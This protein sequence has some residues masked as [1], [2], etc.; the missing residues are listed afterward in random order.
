MSGDNVQPKDVLSGRAILC[1]LKTNIHDHKV[2]RIRLDELR[3]LVEALGLE[4]VSEIVQTR[5]RQFSKYCVGKGKVKEIRSLAEKYD[6]KLV[7]FYNLI[8]SSQKL[9]LIHDT[10]CDVLDR[11]E[12][13]LEIFDQ[14]ASDNLSKL[15]I[16][17]AKL[18]KLSPF[19]KLAA[20]I[21]F[22]HDRPFFHSSGEYAFRAQLREITRRRASI[23]RQIADMMVEKRHQI[24]GRRRLGYPSICIAGYY[25]AGKTS[26][27]NA[28]TGDSKPVSERPFTTLISKYQKRFIDYETTVLFVDTIGFVLDLD[29]RLIKSFQ[30]NFEDIRSADLVILLFEI[31]DPPI[32]LTMKLAEGI[33]LLKDIGVP[34]EKIILVFNKVDKSPEAAETISKDLNLERYGMPW[35]I[36]SA[37]ERIN[38]DGLLSLI[39]TRL[40]ELKGK[41]VETPE[42]E[43][44][45]EAG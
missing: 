34:T 2:F 25:N 6:V 29:H 38:L 21:H 31:T 13:T 15:Q 37:K 1:M 7:V 22:V 18:E 27:F 12:L 26:L 44:A 42:K 24:E 4:V 33:S 32:T 8:N 20:N 41:P 9:N 11:Y 28:L 14:M 45:D 36:V 10:G 35:I 30:I 23:N 43:A 3:A 40:R 16:E 5:F 39:A 19:Y 17:A